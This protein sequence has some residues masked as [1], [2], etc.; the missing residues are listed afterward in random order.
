[1]WETMTSNIQYAN[2]A[3]INSQLDSNKLKAFYF[4]FPRPK[5]AG[6]N[7]AKRLSVICVSLLELVLQQS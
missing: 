7:M 4:G 1:M 3:F 2:A 5:E 6:N